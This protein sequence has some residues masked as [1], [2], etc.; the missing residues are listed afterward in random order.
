M[1][2]FTDEE[3]KAFNRTITITGFVLE[4][5]SVREAVVSEDGSGI[6]LVSKTGGISK[7]FMSTTEAFSLCGSINE[8][9]RLSKK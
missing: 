1:K 7:F 9:I 4:S 8:K 6:T 3:S 5:T 2:E